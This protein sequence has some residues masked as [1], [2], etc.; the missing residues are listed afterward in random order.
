MKRRRLPPPL[1]TLSDDTQAVYDVLNG[2]SN[3]A[4][5]VIGAAYLDACLG[6]LLGRHF[7]ESTV[8]DRLLSPGGTLGSLV[9]RADLA[10][11]LG[12]LSKP[13]YQDLLQIAEIRNL[14]AHHHLQLGFGN[15]EVAEACEKLRYL[16]ILDREQ[17]LNHPDRKESFFR[18]PGLNARDIFTLTVVSAS[19][20]IL[21]KGLGIKRCQPSIA[22]VQAVSREGSNEKTSS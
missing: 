10:Y 15:P 21:L 22:F 20:H 4:V 16:E 9:A 3:L 2:E 6:S 12:F 5:G 17:A 13:L 8:S 14:L 1:E 11:C 7:I 19:S 18:R